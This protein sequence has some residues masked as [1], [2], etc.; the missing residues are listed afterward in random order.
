MYTLIYINTP[1]IGHPHANKHYH[2]LC[3]CFLLPIV[4]LD[5][6]L[7]SI[8]YLNVIFMSSSRVNSLVKVAQS[9][10]QKKLFSNASSVQV[11]T[12][13]TISKQTSNNNI[14]CLQHRSYSSTISSCPFSALKDVDKN[15]KSTVNQSLIPTS[16]STI[17]TIAGKLPIKSAAA[18]LTTDAASITAPSTGCPFSFGSDFPR[19][20]EHPFSLSDAIANSIHKRRG[21]SDAAVESSQVKSFEQIPTSNGWRIFGTSLDLIRKGGAAYLHE[22]CDSLHKKL[23][24]IFREKLGPQECVF[25]ADPEMIR[26]VY[27]NEGKYPHHLVPEA[28]TIYNEMKGIQ[29]GLF[30][31]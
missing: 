16:A 10:L 31:M 25:I 24:L 27:Q 8:Y 13:A 30:F 3:D 1:L 28:W 18:N 15:C 4:V 9:S 21:T 29:R 5:L 23:G 2:H 17:T 26:K 20:E 6:A 19:T 7:S 12:P 14:L 11:S 22:Y